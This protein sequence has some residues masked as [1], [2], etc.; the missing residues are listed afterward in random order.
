MGDVVINNYNF[1]CVFWF[2]TIFHR[3]KEHRNEGLVISQD[4][5]DGSI[6]HLYLTVDEAVSCQNNNEYDIV[7]YL[8]K[9]HYQNIN[10]IK[11]DSGCLKFRFVY[12]NHSRNGFV[13]Y[14]YNRKELVN[15]Y[16]EFVDNSDIENVKNHLA[17][18][19]IKQEGVEDPSEYEIKEYAIDRLFLN[20]YHFAKNIYH[21]HEVQCDSDGRLEAYFYDIDKKGNHRIY[22]TK[23]PNISIKNNDA[24][25]WYIN[26]FE[27]Q[28][29]TY[30]KD[31][32]FSYKTLTQ[33][34]NDVN[35]LISD[36]TN[37]A[38]SNINE[39]DLAKLLSI[40]RWHK[41]TM[42]NTK[43]LVNKKYYIDFVANNISEIKKSFS[44]DVVISE[45]KKLV[46]H[47]SDER[48]KHYHQW[49]NKLELQCGNVL[50]EYTYCKTLI[51]S[52]YNKLY[53]HNQE[54]TEK[55]IQ[56]ISILYNNKEF[57]S[58]LIHKDTCRKKAF[59]IRNCV[60][61][62]EGI[63]QKCLI[64]ENDLFFNI[65]EEISKIS[66]SNQK[67]LNASQKSSRL[68]E[69]LAW[70][71][72]MLGLWGLG[73]A[74]KDTQINYGSSEYNLFIPTIVLGVIC[75]IIGIVRLIIDIRK[76]K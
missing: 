48:L 73:F 36:S 20:C 44:K 47:L 35:K 64:I 15:K 75:F 39:D 45:I 34:I 68:G 66:K 19:L 72:L 22:L 13:V 49:L 62:I 32:S 14:S 10:L 31:V 30:A 24:I 41:F 26:Q 9:K 17:D 12:E 27:K 18:M 28:F 63:R 46:E 6:N 59:N 5:S 42:N 43:Y 50:T 21:E 55:E 33:K 51:E 3:E 8:S 67:I 58:E 11:H 4:I 37:K 70:I 53:S 40:L 74:L 38:I 16:W 56:E 57:D 29:I 76:N 54:I 65:S 71:S 61:Y 2:P 52:K 25:N 1:Y 23:R 69:L 60:R 7:F